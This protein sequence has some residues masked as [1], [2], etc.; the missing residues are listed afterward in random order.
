MPSAGTARAPSAGS[1]LRKAQHSIR[2]EVLRRFLAPAPV[3]EIDPNAPCVTLTEGDPW[4]GS[5]LSGIPL[6]PESTGIRSAPTATRP[7]RAWFLRDA[8]IAPAD[9]VVLSPR[10]RRIMAESLNTGAESLNGG[11]EQAL[12]LR[13]MGKLRPSSF[14]EAA[15]LVFSPGRNYYHTLVDN[16]ARMCAFG[17]PPLSSTHVEM[18]YNEPLTSVERLVI[19]RLRPPN[20]TLRH[21]DSKSLVRAE[22]LMLPT[23]PAWRYS[24]WLPWWYV[25][26][27]RQAVAPDRP[28][29]RSERLY[30]VRRGVRTLTNEK[31]VLRRLDRHGF[32]PVQLEKLSFL[33]QVQLF[34]DAEAVVAAH[35]AGLTNL[36]FANRALVVEICPTRF[37]FPHYV[38]MALSLGHHHRFV[39][40]TRKTR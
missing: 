40:G 21:L 13:R 2:A 29:R 28:S 5:T 32:R 25:Q 33:R 16:L 18:L 6:E 1:L 27:L 22:R 30:I 10:S 31:D 9:G 12:R 39:P 4:N 24:G 15:S 3:D 14:S 23:F 20:V 26:R 38:M 34:H 37:V 8:L 35:G 19:D 36:L 11:K 7:M 17:L